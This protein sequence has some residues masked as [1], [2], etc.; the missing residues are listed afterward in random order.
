MYIPLSSAREIAAESTGVKAVHAF[1]KDDSNLLFVR[2]DRDRSDALAKQIKVIMGEKSTVSTPTSFQE[3]LGSVFV[4]TDKFSLA[5]SVLSLLVAF[6]LVART[7]AANVRERRPEIGTMKAVGWTRRDILGQIGSETLII[8]LLGMVGGLV[9]G[10]VAAKA[11]SLVTI[12]IPI[13]W[14]M[15]PRPHF[16]SGGADQLTR[17]VRL[18]VS[19]SPVLMASAFLASLLI[20]IGSAWAMARSITRL[21]PSEVLRYE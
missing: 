15:S 21:K 12:S 9:L 1:E 6:L 10:F 4:L 14:E 5:I 18:H 2:A 16:M 13:P 7:T 3:M 19:I 8:I 20:G 11:L 17:D